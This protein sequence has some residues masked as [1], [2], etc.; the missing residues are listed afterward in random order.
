M[1]NRKAKE[2]SLY[3]GLNRECVQLARDHLQEEPNSTQNDG[4]HAAYDEF[5]GLPKEHRWR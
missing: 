4:C 1:S 3:L 2:K 5:R